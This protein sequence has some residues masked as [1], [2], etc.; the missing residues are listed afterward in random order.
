MLCRPP[1]LTS[2]AAV[3][4]LASE[5]LASGN[6]DFRKLII[7]RIRRPRRPWWRAGVLTATQEPGL[8]PDK[9]PSRESALPHNRD[10]GVALPGRCLWV[11]WP[12][13]GAQAADQASGLEAVMFTYR[14][15]AM[16]DNVHYPAS[17]LRRRKAVRM[18]VSSILAGTVTAGTVAVSV[19]SGGSLWQFICLGVATLA[20][21]AAVGFPA[22][23][24][25]ASGNGD[26]R[27]LIISRIRRP[28][29]PWWRAGVL[30][31]TQEPGLAPDKIPSRESALPHNRDYGVA[32]P[33]RCLWVPWPTKGAQAADQASGLEAVMF[34]YRASAMQDN[35]HYP[36]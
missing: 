32:L 31:A 7:S 18:I 19:S 29:R 2:V 20:S 36:V 1:Y 27:K 10:Y 26:F 4:F 24:T 15:S 11:P 3:G 33:G 35:V 21:G 9:I 5:T 22:S 25:L 14:A 16:Q 12:T 30:T 6:G 8:T 28:R 17:G 13:K 23:E 34:T